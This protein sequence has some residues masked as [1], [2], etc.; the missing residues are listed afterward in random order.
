[1]V[2]SST[3]FKKVLKVP[4]N[5]DVILRIPEEIPVNAS[6]DVHVSVHGTKK[7]ES[8][9]IIDEPID[10]F[11]TGDEQDSIEDWTAL[12]RNTFDS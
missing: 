8:P 1:M 12:A 5:H 11:L 6:I 7:K 9:A 2:N 3:S 4:K 10:S